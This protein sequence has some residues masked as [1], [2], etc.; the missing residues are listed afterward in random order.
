MTEDASRADPRGD[1]LTRSMLDVVE[2]GLGVGVA[3]ART[4]AVVANGG[5]AVPPPEEDRPIPAI[6][7]YSLAA[8]G[9]LAGLATRAF[10]FRPAPAQASAPGAAPGAAAA[11]PKAAGRSSGPRVRAG[12]TLRVPLSIENPGDQ[13]MG[14]LQ[15]QVRAVRRDG[16][17]AGADLHASAVRFTPGEFVV[18]PKDFEKLTVFVAAPE[19]APPGRY[20]VILA[21]GPRE[22]DLPLSFEV[23]AAED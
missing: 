19:G 15:P 2:A 12:A 17:D 3:L 18:A 4:A 9:E 14:P 7:H 22:A 6:I 1:E 16:V 8:A 10:S 5:K 21:L 20:D 11:T 23:V 13:P